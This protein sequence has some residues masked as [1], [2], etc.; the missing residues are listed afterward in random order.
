MDSKYESSDTYEGFM[1]RQQAN[2]NM[3]IVNQLDTRW[4]LG[5]RFA[6]DAGVA[7]NI[8]NGYEPD[9]RINN[10]VLTDDGYV[11]MKGS[12]IQQRFFSK[13]NDNDLNVRASLKYKL[14]DRFDQRSNILLGY[15]GRFIDD[16]FEAV[17]YDMSVARQHARTPHRHIRRKEK[18]P[19][20]IRRRHIPVYK[21][22]HRQSRP[23]VR[24][25]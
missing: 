9:R 21:A 18:H 6:L 4:R 11:P 23:Q 1:R 13:L 25:R 12:G 22:I 3:L 7:Y 14:K 20:G 10:L 16:G 5:K 15:M 2:D 8:V 19:L 24:Q 17:D